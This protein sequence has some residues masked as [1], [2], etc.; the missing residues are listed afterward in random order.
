MNRDCISRF[1]CLLGRAIEVHRSKLESLDAEDTNEPKFELIDV[2]SSAVDEVAKVGE[3]RA[4]GGQ[5]QIHA[6][7]AQV[8]V[9]RQTVGTKAA[10]AIEPLS[11][12]CI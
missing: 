10:S 5:H 4:F 1:H 12:T 3:S 7:V 8:T 11:F 6:T 9:R 2:G